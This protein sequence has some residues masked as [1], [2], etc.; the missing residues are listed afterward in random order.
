MITV[1]LRRN[2]ASPDDSVKLFS[3][4]PVTAGVSSSDSPVTAGASS[5]ESPASDRANLPSYEELRLIESDALDAPTF[6]LPLPEEI[7]FENVTFENHYPEQTLAIRIKT[8]SAAFLED[9]EVVARAGLL[10]GARYAFDKKE[11]LLTIVFTANAL[12]EFFPVYTHKAG[13]TAIHDSNAIVV[14]CQSPTALYDN[15]I[16][17]DPIP[18]SPQTPDTLAPAGATSRNGTAAEIQEDAALLLAKE[19]QAQ[20]AAL[21]NGTRIYITRTDRETMEKDPILG[22][23]QKSGAVKYLALMLPEGD[24]SLR[25][26]AYFNDRFYIRGYGNLQL[27]ADAEQSLSL[28]ENITLTGVY[29]TGKNGASDTAVT[30]TVL[31]ALK[32]PGALLRI[33][34]L[35]A[36]AQKDE[37]LLSRVAAALLEIL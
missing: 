33:D 10:S 29:A 31:D 27:A 15:I 11:C 8:D 32:I 24:V 2:Y 14:T 22:L 35:S 4:S 26:S 20:A 25:A 28:L 3:S 6:S 1:M 23:I 13:D 21:G 30:E 18:T 12:T 36:A 7:H 9:C 16:V 37:T 17:I 19:I 34:G 5:S